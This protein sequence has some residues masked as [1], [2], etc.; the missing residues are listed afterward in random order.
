MKPFCIAFSLMIGVT[1]QSFGQS[2]RALFLNPNVY[3]TYVPLKCKRIADLEGKP[4]ADTTT[5]TISIESDKATFYLHEEGSQQPYS[6]KAV[7]YKIVNE[8]DNGFVIIRILPCVRL[9]GKT[10]VSDSVKSCEDGPHDYLYAIKK[11][12][13]KPLSKVSLSSRI[14][15]LPL[16]F[17]LKYRPD[18]NGESMNITGEFAAGYSFGLRIKPSRR[19]YQQ[20]YISLLPLTF[21]VGS[22]K[23][24][25]KKQ[26]ETLSEKVDSW[27]LA[28]SYGILFTVQKV[29]FGIFRGHDYMVGRQNNWFYQ[30]KP[31]YSLGIGYKFKTD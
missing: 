6:T 2:A 7:D 25:I 13:L 22:A 3:R 1:L 8:D 5:Y 24:F 18:L 19:P 9:D 14:V 20:F 30:G 27:A 16:L 29:N 31:W 15:G 11:D 4:V 26:D 28:Y 17:P 10:I 23:Y 21:G 12:D